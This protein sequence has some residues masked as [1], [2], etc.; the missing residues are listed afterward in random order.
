MTYNC[1]ALV[2]KAYERIPQE[3][4]D[5]IIATDD[6]SNDGSHE[7]AQAL[8]IPA[9][10]HTPNRGYGGNLK[11][12]LRRALE[13]GADYIV[14]VHGDGQ[15][16]PAAIS[17]AVP[18]MTRGTQFIIGSR[19]IHPRKALANGMPLIRFLANRGLS[20]FDRLVL[21]LPFTEFH[22]GFRI[23]SREMLSRVAWVQNANDYLFSFQ[24][25]AQAAYA[26][27]TVAE[28]PVEADYRGEHTSHS[29]RGASVYALQTFGILAKYLLARWGLRY[30]DIFPPA[31]GVS[32]VTADPAA[33]MKQA[34]RCRGCGE[35]ALREMFRLG[36]VPPVNTFFTTEDS[37][38][39]RAY[40]LTVSCCPRCFL[41]QLTDVVSPEELFRQYQHLSSASAANVRHLRELAESITRR[42]RLRQDAAILD[43]GSNDG[44][45]LAQFRGMTTA[46]LGV[47]PAENLVSYANAQ[48]VEQWT[49]FL[50]ED[51]ADR[52][53][54]ERGKR[55][56]VLALNVVA[57]TPDVNALLRAVKRILKPGGTFV[58]ETV[59][60]FATI[61]RGEFD[62]VY[63]EHVYCFS[64]ASLLPLLQYAGLMVTDAERIPTQGGSLRIFASPAEEQP[65]VSPNV[66]AL[67][68]EEERAGG[69]DLAAY[70]RAG[71][72]VR[73][74][75][76][77][78]RQRV[79]EL[80]LRHGRVWG[81]GAP[82]RGVVMLNFADIGSDLLEAV[83]DDT[84]LK[85]GRV[86]PG[87]HI[88]VVSW[89]ALGENPPTAFL[90]LSWNYAEHLLERL[91]ATVPSAAVLIPFPEMREVV[92]TAVPAHVPERVH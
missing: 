78:L 59:D 66:A 10:R 40:P 58:M 72:R 70:L 18:Q 26:G 80:H 55:D 65:E 76:E 82:A 48:G 88:P 17:R 75:R 86:V 54:R 7:A 5:E 23:Y 12:G 74:F 64:L 41:V 19:F 50:S 39:E 77:E 14:E 68:Q 3:A 56:L 27:L 4:V 85:Q 63:H 91:C 33:G 90:L 71:G 79:R 73:E 38:R 42:L 35:V 34:K 30:C 11:E 2:K 62:T 84:P 31:R 53:V 49:T 21:G 16:D 28:V 61:L 15:F 69:R 67:L 92:L 60:V 83:V 51:V 22:T 45:L 13:Q 29:I 52:I 24:I 47:D 8:G 57:H 20:F 9:F 46:L 87:A 36:A 25:I 32:K 81:I 89:D 37:S 43:I 1:A 6:G 44:T